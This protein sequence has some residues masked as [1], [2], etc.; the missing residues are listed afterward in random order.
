[1][2]SPT[3][4]V[5]ST[6]PPSSEYKDQVG[7][8]RGQ[9]ISVSRASDLVASRSTAGPVTG[10]FT[11]VAWAETTRVGCGY[12]DYVSVQ[13][14]TKMNSR[15]VICNYKESG[16]FMGKKMYEAGAAASKCPAGTKKDATY[17][18]LCA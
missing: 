10:H 18:G 14:G 7:E 17:K 4:T 3:A 6:P 2:R 13:S 12:V 8:G 9:W 5:A 1:M 11:Q 16:N 15:M